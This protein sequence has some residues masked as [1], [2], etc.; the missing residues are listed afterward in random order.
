MGHVSTEKAARYEKRKAVATASYQKKNRVIFFQAT[1]SVYAKQEGLQH[2]LPNS[3][4]VKSDRSSKYVMMET[5]Y[6]RSELVR[7]IRRRRPIPLPKLLP[8]D[9]GRVWPCEGA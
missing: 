4:T 1:L 2:F 5:F 9:V 6:F 8:E 7:L 3:S